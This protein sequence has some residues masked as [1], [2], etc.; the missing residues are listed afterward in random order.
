[1]AE[2]DRWTSSY[3]DPDQLDRSITELQDSKSSLQ[4]EL[5]KLREANMVI[6]LDDKF[7][8]LIML[9]LFIKVNFRLPLI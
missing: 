1:M 9:L 5:Q 6:K 4:L 2:L 3:V 8:N 7:K